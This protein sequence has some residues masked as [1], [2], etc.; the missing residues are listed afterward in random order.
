MNSKI[1]K[2]YLDIGLA[3]QAIADDLAGKLLVYSEVQD[4]VVSADLFY[5]D[6]AGV[7]RFRF[8][9]TTMKDL[10]YSF[11]ER[12]Q[13]EPN[14]H[15]WRVMC[16]VMEDGKFSI[17]LTYLD[18]IKADEGVSDRRPFAVRRHFN[19]MKVDYSKP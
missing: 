19:D 16:Y 6:K 2:L 15:E 10:I 3:A 17:D 5:V 9:P 13:E 12:W 8:C 4:G 11:W 18:Q 7:V 14:S 1:E